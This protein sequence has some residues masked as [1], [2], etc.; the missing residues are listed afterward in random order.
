MITR[1]I[2]NKKQAFKIPMIIFTVLLSISLV[3]FFAYSPL[4]IDSPQNQ[5]YVTEAQR[6]M[7]QINRLEQG[8]KA[9]PKNINLLIGL[10]N[11]FYDLSMFYAAY[12]DLE[13][14]AKY[15][16]ESTKPYLQALEIDADLVA[17]R[18]DLATAFFYAGEYDLAEEQ[19]KLAIESDPTFINSLVNYGVFLYSVREDKEAALEQW[20]AALKLEPDPV[21][22]A[23]IEEMITRV[24]EGMQQQD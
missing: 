2:R 20:E 8:V 14:A 22:A 12:G 6:M 21:I 3:G 19:F 5:G 9:D 13:K 1:T 7:E 10:G 11:H 23:S 15:I 4:Q 18:V 17:V 24:S 16:E